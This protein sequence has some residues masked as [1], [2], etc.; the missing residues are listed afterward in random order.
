MLATAH[1][2]CALLIDCMR[3]RYL[4]PGES[5]D[6]VGLNPVGGSVRV[7]LANG[8]DTHEVK[9]VPVN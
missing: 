6:L 4:S 3:D 1:G 9:V 7:V 2:E 8:T 5:L